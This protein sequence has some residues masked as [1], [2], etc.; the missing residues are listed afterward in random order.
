MF[1]KN[2]FASDYF[3]VSE[4]MQLNVV[5]L[6]RAVSKTRHKREN[7]PHC[8]RWLLLVDHLNLQLYF[9]NLYFFIGFFFFRMRGRWKDRMTF[10]KSSSPVERSSIYF[11]HWVSCIHPHSRSLPSPLG[12][13][14]CVSYLSPAVFLSVITF[15]LTSH[16]VAK[17]KDQHWP[18][19]YKFSAQHVCFA[20]L[21][22]F[23]S[24]LRRKHQV[25]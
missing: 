12:K 16:P 18:S 22:L 13:G 19:S 8:F 25:Y 14:H 1:E 23:T 7:K 21:P 10:W 3:W 17:T 24:L 5:S 4:P 9:L 2:S 11:S 6:L 20:P 15:L